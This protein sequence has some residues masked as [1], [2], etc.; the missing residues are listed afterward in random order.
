MVGRG[1]APADFDLC[2]DLF[3]L[4]AQ[5]N[6]ELETYLTDQTR[7]MQEVADYFWRKAFS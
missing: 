2:D 7:L 1:Y 3:R 6:A 4:E 5:L